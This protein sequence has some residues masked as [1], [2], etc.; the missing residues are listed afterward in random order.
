MQMGCC[1]KLGLKYKVNYDVLR[2]YIT[3]I[4]YITKAHLIISKSL[5]LM[6]AFDYYI[7][8]VDIID[9]ITR[10]ESKNRHQYGIIIRRLK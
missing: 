3:L 7:R 1:S 10:S 2:Y 9:R 4:L 5:K 6:K 8:S